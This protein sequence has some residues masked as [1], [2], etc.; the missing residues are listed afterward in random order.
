MAE[1]K[2]TGGNQQPSTLPHLKERSEQARMPRLIP[3]LIQEHRPMEV[4][5][6]RHRR[7]PVRAQLPASSPLGTIQCPAAVNRSPYRNPGRSLS[8]KVD[9]AAA[10]TSRSQSLYRSN[11]AVPDRNHKHKR[12]PCRIHSNHILL[13]NSSSSSSPRHTYRN[14]CN[15]KQRFPLDSERQSTTMRPLPTTSRVR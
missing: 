3:P 1:F 4:A 13:N 10:R 8:S 14:T 6:I 15:R 2:R 5:A 12:M 9:V 11:R 7:H